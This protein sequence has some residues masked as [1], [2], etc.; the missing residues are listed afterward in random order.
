MQLNVK[1]IKY[2]RWS[3]FCKENA[4]YAHILWNKLNVVHI[5]IVHIQTSYGGSKTVCLTYQQMTQSIEG[6]NYH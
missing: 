4:K 1:Q 5:H 3:H 2:H 6:N